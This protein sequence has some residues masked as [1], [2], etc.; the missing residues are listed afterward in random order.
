MSHG[1]VFFESGKWGND[2]DHPEYVNSMLVPVSPQW[3]TSEALMG[4]TYRRYVLG[5]SEKSVDRQKLS[6]LS[7]SIPGDSDEKGL[8]QSLLSESGGLRSPVLKR[9]TGDLLQVMPLVPN[10]AKYGCIL[11]SKSTHRWDPGSLIDSAFR[12]GTGPAGY[13]SFISDFK[14]ALAVG[15]DD[16][17]LA[18]FVQEGLDLG[19]GTAQPR[20]PSRETFAWRDGSGSDSGLP[21]AERM[22][23]DLRVAIK[24][25]GTLT[26]RQW[27]AFLE[28]ILRLGLGMHELWLARLNSQ[29]WEAA[30]VVLDGGEVPS[31]DAIERWW[32]S[33]RDGAGLIEL[34]APFRTGLSRQI[35]RLFQARLGL[36]LLLSCLDEAGV[37]TASALGKPTVEENPKATTG[38]SVAVLWSF[39][40]LVAQQRVHISGALNAWREK[41]GRRAESLRGVAN[42]IADLNQNVARGSAG[43]TKN[44]TEF[45]VYLLQQL[46]PR[47]AEDMAYD[48]GYV[49]RQRGSSRSQWLACLGPSVLVFAVHACCSDL[50]GAA[51]TLDDLQEYL[52]D[53]GIEASMD[54]LQSGQTG[55]SLVRLGL[56]ADSPDAT[57]GRLLVNPFPPS[58]R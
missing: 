8:W 11:G 12:S 13:D 56:V 31:R 39:L 23:R 36:D 9:E 49:A 4:A 40:N 1:L 53:Y 2:M 50:G 10:L 17:L 58:R 5:V 16:D 15:P 28:S 21:P 55:L 20:G 30:C 6:Q 51:G 26:R 7:Q 19:T 37:P 52:R 18:R 34:G 24:L 41:T 43:F 22:V 44:V 46:V 38:D 14:D 27:T 42:E 45:V 54:E 48:Q 32:T 29:L 47:G 25:K 57:S 33:H 35:A 3:T